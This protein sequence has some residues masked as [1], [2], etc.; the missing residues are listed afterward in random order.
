MHCVIGKLLAR[1]EES[2][3]PETGTFNSLKH[4]MSYYLSQDENALRGH[5]GLLGVLIKLMEIYLEVRCKI[6]K[7][8]LSFLLFE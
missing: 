5:S 8:M 7:N 1:L 6:L 4:T 2:E 3:L